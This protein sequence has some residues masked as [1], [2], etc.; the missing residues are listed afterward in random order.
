M[1]S[2]HSNETVSRTVF[3]SGTRESK[4]GPNQ[5]NAVVV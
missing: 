1:C 3:V 5:S 2:W 4:M